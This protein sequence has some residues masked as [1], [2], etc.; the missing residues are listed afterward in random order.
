MVE[1]GVTVEPGQYVSVAPYT[2]YPYS[3]GYVHIT[4]PELDDPLDFDVGFFSD[5]N[6]LDIKKQVWAYKKG[7]EIM[8]RTSSKPPVPE[9]RRESPPA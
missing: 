1:E 7:R 2:A 3:R 4:G 6:N 9:P 8:R 5:K